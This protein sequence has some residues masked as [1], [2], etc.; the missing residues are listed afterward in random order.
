M[1][2]I[3]VCELS[4]FVL[5]SIFNIPFFPSLSKFFALFFKVDFTKQRQ[6]QELIMLY[7]N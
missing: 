2:E 6:I 1:R 4:K 5:F 7:I 3:F